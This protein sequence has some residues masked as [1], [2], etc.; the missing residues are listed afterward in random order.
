MRTTPLEKLREADLPVSIKK[1]FK[2]IEE[3]EKN[4]LKESIKLSRRKISIHKIQNHHELIIPELDSNNSANQSNINSKKKQK[5]AHFEIIKIELG[6]EQGSSS[7]ETEKSVVISK[8][9]NSEEKQ[10]EFKEGLSNSNSLAKDLDM[11]DEENVWKFFESSA[12]EKF[13]NEF[14]QRH[15]SKKDYIG[16]SPKISSKIEKSP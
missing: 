13:E 12:P 7:L 8:K 6:G 4:K 5:N 11:N 10:D 15:Y 2:S 3:S 1:L 9:G 14:Y 16:I